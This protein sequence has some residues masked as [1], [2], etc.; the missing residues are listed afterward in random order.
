MTTSI[1]RVALVAVGD[2]LLSGD[3]VNGNGAVLGRELGAI[4]AKV[5]AHH[6]V[7]DDIP[8]I[9]DAVLGAAVGADAVVVCGGLGPTQ[10]DVTREGIAAAAGVE[11]MRDSEV[12]RSLRALF[13]SLAIDRDIPEMNWRQ[14]EVPSGATTLTN[15][16]GSAP[17]L[18]LIV[19][20]TLVYV[21]PGVPSEFNA[22]LAEAV[23]PDLIT[24]FPKRPAIVREVIRTVGMWESAVAQ[25]LAGEV[26]RTAGRPA[27]SFLAT[28]GETRV[29][30]TATADTADAAE[31][32]AE[33]TVTAA[34]AALGAAVYDAP[35]LEA[36]VIGL[37][38]AAG[39]TVACA[40]S[41]TAGLVTARL[42]NVPGASA[43]LRGGVI[44]YATDL[45]SSLLDI[46]SSDI[47]TWQAVSPQTAEAMAEAVA[48]ACDATYGLALTGVAGP[49]EQDGH[50]PGTVFIGLSGP[51][52]VVSRQVALPGERAQVRAFAVT[53]ALGLLRSA[54]VQ[55]RQ[56]RD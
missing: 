29:V 15:T 37:L 55:D 16:V 41:L 31:A 42:A 5:V 46:S 49:A 32:L 23:I 54:L 1:L 9:R 21:L 20:G 34:R 13:T 39:A 38:S 27:I 14:A 43:V 8:V 33:P 50:P 19:S 35:T 3:Q 18:Q 28:G 51:S 10:D 26:T 36:D 40:E 30:I 45:K 56:H 48:K 4:G 22:M 11:L 24:R 7:G 17:G 12:E 6:V 47:A 52:G 25:A 53:S 44:P 2:E